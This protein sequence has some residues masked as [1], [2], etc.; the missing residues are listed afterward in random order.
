MREAKTGHFTETSDAAQV[1]QPSM[2]VHRRTFGIV[3]HW[4]HGLPELELRR[5]KNSSRVAA[6]L[7]A[8]WALCLHS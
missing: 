2:S 6:Y 3:P 5:R 7:D 8:P 4:F 1:L